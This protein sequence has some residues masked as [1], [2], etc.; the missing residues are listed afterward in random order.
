MALTAKARMIIVVNIEFLILR[1]FGEK[2]Q[3]NS[4]VK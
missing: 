2:Y 3:L 1:I 4:V